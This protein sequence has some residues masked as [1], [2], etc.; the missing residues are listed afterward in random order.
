MAP[1]LAMLMGVIS[2][3]S[4]D[5]SRMT[6]SGPGSMVASRGKDT[7]T[8][9]SAWGGRWVWGMCAASQS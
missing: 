7:Q 1:H 4:R 5:S 3:G 2:S 9:Y 8:G 6:V